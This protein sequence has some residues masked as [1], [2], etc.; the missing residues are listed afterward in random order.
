MNIFKCPKCG[1]K[2]DLDIEEHI[3]GASKPTTKPK[4]EAKK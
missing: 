1:G 2:T 4:K 3:C